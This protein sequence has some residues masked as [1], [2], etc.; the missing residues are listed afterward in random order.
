MVGEKE[1]ILNRRDSGKAETDGVSYSRRKTEKKAKFENDIDATDIEI[2][3]VYEH[4][5]LVDKFVQVI[6]MFKSSLLLVSNM[7]AK[8]SISVS[9]KLVTT[10]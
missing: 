8:L 7:F 9:S 5:H 2:K 4:Q 1:G 3:G 10:F 6:L